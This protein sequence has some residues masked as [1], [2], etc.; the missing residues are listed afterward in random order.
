MRIKSLRTIAPSAITLTRFAAALAFV[1]LFETSSRML[2]FAIFAAAAL[3][4][5]LDGFLAR[6]F[7]VSSNFGAYLDVT[8]DFALIAA[9]FLAFEKK[10]WYGALE[11]GIIALSFIGFITSSSRERPIYDPVGRYM[12][13]FLMAMIM[14]TLALPFQF[15]RTCL[16]LLLCAFFA[17]SVLS[18]IGFL[19]SRRE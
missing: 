9:G 7:A 17:L 4:D 5:L 2:A 1:Y 10:N 6:R 8:A 16:T 18:R 11:L 3:T 15:A 14:A 13:A 19:I 12:G